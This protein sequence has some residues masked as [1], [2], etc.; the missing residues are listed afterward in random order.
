MSLPPDASRMQGAEAGNPDARLAMDTFCYSASKQV[1]AMS[2]VL[3]GAESLVFTG[4]IGENDPQV[5]AAI[6]E[7]LASIGLVLDL[8]R[9]RATADPISDPSSRC[10][11]RVLPSQEDEQIA[12]ETW[13]LC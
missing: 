6:C 1:A 3:G 9:N 5:R 7:R 8:G 10:Q 11:V 13:R 4:G 12:R 2:A